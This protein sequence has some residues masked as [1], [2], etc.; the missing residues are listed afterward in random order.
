M[1]EIK[2]PEEEAISLLKEQVQQE[3][4]SRKKI[5]EL[6]PEDSIETINFDT[7]L[8]IIETAIFDIIVLL[9]VTLI[10]EKSNL[11]KI[12]TTSVKGFLR[13]NKRFGAKNFSDK[14]ARAILKK[15]QSL[16]SGT[17]SSTSFQ[18]N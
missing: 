13:V 4:V 15:V 10:I 8:E 16:F 2:V 6:H 12:I 14:N 3:I 18:Q 11:P 5:N 7:L 17:S 9:P 1:I